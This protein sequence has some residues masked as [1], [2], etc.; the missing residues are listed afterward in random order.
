MTSVI[1]AIQIGETASL[2]DAMKAMREGG[3]G[4]VCVRTKAGRVIG[5]LSDG[6]IRNALLEGRSM[7]DD[8]AKV[9]TRD[10]VYVRSDQTEKEAREL[11][12]N[13]IRVVPILNAEGQLTG[14]VNPAVIPV[15]EPNFLERE[16]KLLMECI[17]TGWISS[18]GRFI[19]AFEEIFARRM[20]MPYGVAT[21]NCTTALHLALVALGIGSG[22]EVLCPDLTFISPANMIRLTGATA[23]LVDVEP[24]S[25]GMDVRHAAAKITPKTKA[26]M[27]VH[28][29]GHSA[30]MDPIT[31]LAKK[32]GLRVIEDSAEAPGALYKGRAIGSIGDLSCFSFFA[33]KIV[34][35]GE[36]G[37]VLCRDKEMD[38]SL[39]MLRD[40]GMS[41]EKR[42]VHDVIGFNYRMTNMQAA[43]GIAQMEQFD[44]I[45]IQRDAQAAHY[46][47][48]FSE[49]RTVRWRPTLD[50]CRP[51][52]WLATI[53]LDD[54]S[55]RDPLIEHLGMVGIDARPMVYPI[56]MAK[57]YQAGNDPRDFPIS[58][59]IGLR[60]L[61]LP[62]STKLSTA[63]IDRICDSVM[64]WTDVRRV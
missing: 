22:D 31:A 51:V 24:E 28:A 61:H 14:L 18:Q 44:S 1:E 25:L 37:M 52:H 27:V 12:S 57:P 7:D 32:H 63:Q 30:D 16:R 5:V 53:T 41:R 4:L 21:S 59:S 62:S 13:K 58:R 42:Y 20:T 35:T 45:L 9:M 49:S 29:F 2:R 46:Q 11:L 43:I 56:H 60:S 3:K 23:V 64:E 55:L 54:E 34:T 39:R 47:R 19:P 48:R 33:N 8:A 50:Y 38:K 40:H 6:D 36:G 26:I 15:F 10:F 17:D